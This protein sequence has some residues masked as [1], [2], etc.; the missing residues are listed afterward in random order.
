MDIGSTSTLV[1]LDPDQMNWETLSSDDG[2]P[3]FTPST[4][5]VTLISFVRDVSYH[6]AWFPEDPAIT[7]LNWP[8]LGV[9]SRVWMK[10]EA[11]ESDEL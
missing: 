10:I 9:E 6:P 2:F 1:E 5:D 8:V 7:S 4:S 3:A 11:D